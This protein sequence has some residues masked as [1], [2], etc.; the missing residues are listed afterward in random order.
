MCDIIVCLSTLTP[1]PL[2]WI[3]MHLLSYLVM[4]T[5]T[6]SKIWKNPCKSTYLGLQQFS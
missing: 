5:G 6:S 3:V 1:S 2:S 4:L